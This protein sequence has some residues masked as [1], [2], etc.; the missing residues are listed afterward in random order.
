MIL[1][2][3]S[4]LETFGKEFNTDDEVIEEA[5][6][7][8]ESIPTAIRK[9]YPEDMFEAAVWYAD[10]Y[11][12]ASAFLDG[13]IKAS[14]ETEEEES[15]LDKVISMISATIRDKQAMAETRPQEESVDKKP[16]R[17]EKLGTKQAL[18][19]LKSTL[20]LYGIECSNDEAVL[21]TA[22]EITGA[23]LPANR[24]QYSNDTVVAAIEFAPKYYGSR[25]TVVNASKAGELVDKSAAYACF[26]I[27]TAF[28]FHDFL[29]K[30]SIHVAGELTIKKGELSGYMLDSMKKD[31]NPHVYLVASFSVLQKNEQ[32]ISARVNSGDLVIDVG[33]NIARLSDLASKTESKPRSH[34]GVREIPPTSESRMEEII[35]RIEADTKKLPTV[36]EYAKILEKI[37]K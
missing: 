8:V 2:L 5:E 24:D 3:R 26:K 32:L 36:E 1:H 16:V 35:R 7:I 30:Y 37:K 23:I 17:V 28:K 6:R 14:A 12:N 22:N 11:Y 27:D 18:D 25:D 19:E 9:E 29:R 31:P 34:F 13:L 20:K 21:L 15:A 33:G 4:L 10:K